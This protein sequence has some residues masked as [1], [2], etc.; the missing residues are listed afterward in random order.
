MKNALC[1]KEVAFAQGCFSAMFCLV[2]WSK[3]LQSQLST[4]HALTSAC[5]AMTRS[6]SQ[7]LLRFQSREHVHS[8]L[9]LW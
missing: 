8:L 9:N 7:Q 4:A 6:E 5:T 1:V 3:L 2:P